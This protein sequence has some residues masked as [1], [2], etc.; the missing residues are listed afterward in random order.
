MIAIAPAVCRTIDP[1]PKAISATSVTYSA[2]PMIATSTVDGWI[3]SVPEKVVTRCPLQP[4]PLPSGAEP[5][6]PPTQLVIAWAGIVTVWNSEAATPLPD[7][8][9]WPAKNARNEVTSEITS[10]TAVNVIAL[11]A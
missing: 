11:A 6:P 1:T 10:V 7:S 9:A 8:I 2:V 5:A 4:G 3:T